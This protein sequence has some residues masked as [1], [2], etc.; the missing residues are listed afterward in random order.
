M[1]C[2]TAGD[3]RASACETGYSKVAGG[4]G[5]HDTC[6]ANTCIASNA[7]NLQA[8]G[9]TAATP[10]A[11]TAAGLGNLGCYSSTH[12]VVEGAT[13]Q[14]I[15]KPNGQYQLTGASGFQVRHRA[16]WMASTPG[17][18]ASRGTPPQPGLRP[19]FFARWA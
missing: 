11:T 19:A 18:R 13:V 5:A 17:C 4:V 16:S 12:R 1:T 9:Y 2:T 15:C 8:L 3:S 6:V 7:A 10:T 14:A